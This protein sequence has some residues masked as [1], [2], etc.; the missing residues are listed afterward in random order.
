[1]LLRQVR[2][3]GLARDF[4]PRD[5]FYHRLPFSVRTAP[6]VQLCALTPVCTLKILN[7]GSHSFA[8]TDENTTYTVRNGYHVLAVAVALPG[9]AN[10]ISRKG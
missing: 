2:L 8:W 9:K 5:N 10:Q 3:P 4:S 1:M 7:N 6:C